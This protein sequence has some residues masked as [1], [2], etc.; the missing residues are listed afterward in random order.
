SLTGVVLLTE[1]LD[2]GDVLDQ[3]AAFGESQ[4]LPQIL[5]LSIDRGG[6]ESLRQAVIDIAVNVTLG[7]LIHSKLSKP[8]SHWL[9]VV[10]DDVS[11]SEFSSLTILLECIK[12][13]LHRERI[14]LETLERAPDHLTHIEG[15]EVLR[16]PLFMVVS[17]DSV[18]ERATTCGEA[19]AAR[20]G[21]ESP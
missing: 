16:F 14:F 2:I 4:G 20:A 19:L 1:F 12:E 18:E 21:H 15:E 6:R 13:F 11:T 10:S 5:Q 3:F 8:C 9:Q 17:L 7:E